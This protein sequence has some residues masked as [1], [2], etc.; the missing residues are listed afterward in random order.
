MGTRRFSFDII[1]LENRFFSV[2]SVVMGRG[3]AIRGFSGDSGSF[4]VS[5][6]ASSSFLLFPTN[7]DAIGR[8]GVRGL[9]SSSRKYCSPFSPL[10]L[11]NDR[12]L[13]YLPGLFGLCGALSSTVLQIRQLR[14]DLENEGICVQCLH[15]I[16]YPSKVLHKSPLSTPCRER[17]SNVAGAKDARYQPYIIPCLIEYLVEGQWQSSGGTGKERGCRRHLTPR[18]RGWP[19]RRDGKQ[20]L[21]NFLS[22]R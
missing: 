11:C 21:G 20:E 3:R 14:F 6:M 9:V 5:G 10:L 15:G 2:P 13:P 18:I 7:S 19:A 8:V 4:R 1:P 22:K 16:F 12:V 17:L